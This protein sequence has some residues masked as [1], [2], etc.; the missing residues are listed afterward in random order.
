MTKRKD[1]DSDVQTEETTPPGLVT[2]LGT[3]SETFLDRMNVER[4][5]LQE[6]VSKLDAF[7]NGETFGGIDQ[8]E[9]E[10]LLGQRT[11]MGHYLEILSARIAYHE[12]QSVAI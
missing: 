12:K 1:H 3:A 5:E 10:R 6:R 7:I 4:M 11:A 9:R 2:T 8:E